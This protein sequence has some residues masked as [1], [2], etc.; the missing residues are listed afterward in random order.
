MPTPVGRYF[1]AFEIG[2]QR[3]T[4]VGEQPY[5]RKRDGQQTTLALWQ[6]PCVDCGETFTI[7]ATNRPVPLAPQ[8]RCRPCAELARQ[9]RAEVP[10]S[11]STSTVTYGAPFGGRMAQ[12]ETGRPAPRTE[13]PAGSQDVL[14]GAPAA[15]VAPAVRPSKARQ[16]GATKRAATDKRS[17]FT[18]R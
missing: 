14:Q 10:Y 7:P 5:T 9:A 1:D 18:D 16:T 15:N 6:A 8:R 17:A 3:Y 11:A 12:G 4:R 13:A 2:A